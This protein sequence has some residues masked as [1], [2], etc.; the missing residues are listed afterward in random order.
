MTETAENNLS[1]KDIAGDKTLTYLLRKPSASDAQQIFALVAN[2]PPLDPNSLYCNLL[3]CSHFADTAVVCVA[4]EKVVAFMTGY[5]KPGQSNELFVWQMAV[6]QSMRG[7]G[8]AGKML[9]FLCD[10]WQPTYIETTITEANT[11]SAAVFTRFVQ[12]TDSV[13]SKSILFDKDAHFSGRHDSEIL[14]RIGPIT[15]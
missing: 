13:L 10:K 5:L 8:V 1:T 2:N 14:Y 9:Q 11:A 7:Q 6:D 12:R 4:D 15:Y 3:Q